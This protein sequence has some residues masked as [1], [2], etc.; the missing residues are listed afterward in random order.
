MLTDGE[1]DINWEYDWV[2]DGRDEHYVD[3]TH[4]NAITVCVEHITDVCINVWSLSMWSSTKYSNSLNRNLRQRA[5]WR[6]GNEYCGD[7][8]EPMWCNGSI[9]A[10]NARY[11]G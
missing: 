5:T 7:I 11:V 3:N 4:I 8:R 2:Y 6:G 1:Y 10:G 9:L